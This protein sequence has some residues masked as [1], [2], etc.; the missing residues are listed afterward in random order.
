MERA[1]EKTKKRKKKK[2]QNKKKKNKKKTKKTL[3]GGSVTCPLV[4]YCRLGA[5]ARQAI[6]AFIVRGKRTLAS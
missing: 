1:K 5:V 3:T 4:G 6:Q 2:K